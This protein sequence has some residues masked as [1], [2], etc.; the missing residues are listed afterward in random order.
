MSNDRP[1][2]IIS[3]ADIPETMHKYPN[4]DESMA[5][6]RAIGRAAGL[7]RVGLHVQRVPPGYRI[8]WPH[9]DDIPKKPQGSHDGKPDGLR[10]KELSAK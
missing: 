9:A 1:P 5:P 3:S 6:S 2:F 8:S 7:L 10:A 4:S